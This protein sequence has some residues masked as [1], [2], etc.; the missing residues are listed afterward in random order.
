MLKV[1]SKLKIEIELSKGAQI[2][3]VNYGTKFGSSNENPA[4]GEMT[5]IAHELKI[6]SKLPS[7]KK[8]WQS[9]SLLKVDS[10]IKPK[11][12][13]YGKQDNISI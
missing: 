2:F 8:N 12:F 4:S 10:K 9:K 5:I 1:F 3:H 7:F 13:F 11:G 6:P